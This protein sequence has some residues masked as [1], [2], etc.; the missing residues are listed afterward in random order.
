M[1]LE[2]TDRAEADLEAIFDYLA[3]HNPTAAIAVLKAIHERVAA[4]KDFP[5][6]GQPTSRHGVRS[7]TIRGYPYKAYY[8]VRPT[9]ILILHV[10]DARRR[11]WIGA[12]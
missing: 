1:R 8:R 3:K 5:W 9:R 11:P 2:Y 6:S 4:L 7:V 10:R 12:R